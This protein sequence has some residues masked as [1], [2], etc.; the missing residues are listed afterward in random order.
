MVI[1]TPFG[2][3][4]LDI[5][6]FF[7]NTGNTTTYPPYNVIKHGDG[8]IADEYVMEFAV[9]GFKKEDITIK[10]V[11]DD[12][13]AT[14]MDDYVNGFDVIKTNYFEIDSY[15]CLFIKDEVIKQTVDNNKAAGVF[16]YFDINTKRVYYN[17]LYNDFLINTSI[18]TKYNIIGEK[19]G[20]SIQ[21]KINT[22]IVTDE[23]YFNNLMD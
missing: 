21:P 5:D 17:K 16:V 12:D 23:D 1:T 15:V 18:N 4:G 10:K 7:S 20:F 9:A 11:N 2:G 13:I 14:L 6:K 8:S 3:L 19:S 22:I